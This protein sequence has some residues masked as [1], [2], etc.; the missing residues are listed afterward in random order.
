MSACKNWRKENKGLDNSNSTW[1][2]F[3]EKESPRHFASASC[4]FSHP[5][6]RTSGKH[7]EAA[8]AGVLPF[9]RDPQSGVTFFLL[10]RER[11]RRNRHGISVW[12]DFGGGI[13]HGANSMVG[14]SREFAEETLGIVVGSGGNGASLEFVTE[15]SCTDQPIRSMFGNAVP[16]DMYL[17]EI[18]YDGALP[19]KFHQRRDIAQSVKAREQLS[20]VLPRK[21]FS[22]SGRVTNSYLEKDC[23]AWV[24]LDNMFCYANKA[25]E[26][27]CIILRP[28]FAQ[29]VNHFAWRIQDA[30][31]KDP[32]KIM[33]A[34][35]E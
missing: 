35:L 21:A 27:S 6:K 33:H 4:R 9:A 13:S 15:H 17:I 10:G 3:R 34:L 32:K 20:H 24:S 19:A 30:V 25:W 16:Y 5:R 7:I 31:A 1:I 26:E 29:T 2:A 23:I 11:D 18:S 28:E 8:S 22:S 12:C 14:A